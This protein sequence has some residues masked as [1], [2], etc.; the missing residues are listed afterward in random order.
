MRTRGL[1]GLVLSMLLL[2][3]LGCGGGGTVAVTP[4]QATTALS[5]MASKG[6][7]QAGTVIAYPVRFGAVDT[8]APIVQGQTDGGGNY[9]IDIGLYRGPVVVE[10]VGGTFTDEVSGTTVTLKAPMR[11]VFSNISTGK[12]TVA[13][14]PLTELA[15][16]KAIGAGALTAESISS[17][18]TSL[19]ATFGLKDIISTLPDPGNSG[20]EQKKYAAA[21]GSISQLV[22]NN[23]KTGESLDDALGRLLTQLGNE[24]EQDGAF[25]AASATVINGAI[26][27]YNNAT[28]TTGTIIAPIPSP[29]SG[30]LALSTA[31]TASVIA[32]I[33]ITVNL[34]PGIIVNADPITGIVTDGVVTISGV[35]AVGTSNVTVAKFSP[36]SI[37]TS[38][39]LHV[40]M[41]N[42]LGFPLG[43]FVTIKFDLTTG[44]TFPTA[45]SFS[46]TKFIAKGLDGAALS[47][48]TAAPASVVGI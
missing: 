2:T 36:A 34:P 31:G 11:T 42:G 7:I 12:K 38:A 20:A 6:P 19:A 39:N 43:E 5:G 46:V 18:N 14:T 29:T 21:C 1:I 47:G 48:I 16:R 33:D 28:N 27:A 44:A 25:S 40:I 10:V 17:A 22:N 9:S 3:L 4:Q 15:F 37:G 35:A 30:V 8:T 23:K 32:G 41:A 26:T 24:Q 45:N 13:I